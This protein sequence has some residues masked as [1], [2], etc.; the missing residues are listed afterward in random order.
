[1]L[2]ELS[3]SSL[4]LQLLFYRKEERKRTLK[5]YLVIVDSAVYFTS[6]FF[7]FCKFKDFLQL[8]INAASDDKTGAKQKLTDDDI[9]GNAITFMLAGYDTTSNTLGYTCYL[10]ALN[11]HVQEKLQQEIDNYYE[12][13]PVIVLVLL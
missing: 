7:S 3:D 1:M 12:E 11:P 6:Y 9:I 5:R 13:N 2:K 4:Q 10:L 8:M